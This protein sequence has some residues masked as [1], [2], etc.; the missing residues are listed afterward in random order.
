LLHGNADLVT[1]RD[2]PGERARF[3]GLAFVAALVV[4]E[5]VTAETSN[6]TTVSVLVRVDNNQEA[7]RTAL[8]VVYRMSGIDPKQT[9]AHSGVAPASDQKRKRVG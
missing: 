2:H 1:E 8:G 6:L 4:I 9:C 7:S 3:R 5:P